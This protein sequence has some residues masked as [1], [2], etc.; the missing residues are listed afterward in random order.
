MD[1]PD[2]EPRALLAL[3]HIEQALEASGLE[4]DVEMKEGGVLEVEFSD[5]SKMIINRHGVAK[6]IWIAARAGGFHFRWDGAQWRDTR[7]GTE[8]FS[9]L[10]RLVSAQ[11]GHAVLLAAPKPG[12]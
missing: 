3:S 7:E 12:A 10:S 4:L 9:A 8:L 5:G 11:A 2:F 6:E 1:F